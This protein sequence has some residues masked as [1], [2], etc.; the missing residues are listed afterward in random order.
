MGTGSSARALTRT[1]NEWF[2]EQTSDPKFDNRFGFFGVLPDW[3]DVDGTLAE[4]DY[5]YQTQRLC[6]GITTYTSYGGKLLGDSTFKPIWEKLQSYKALV[7]IHPT[8]L[9]ITPSHLAGSF[10]QPIIDFPLATTRTAADLV[11]S[12][13]M[14]S[15]PDVDVILSHAGGALPC[16][17]DRLSSAMQV[18]EIQ[19]Q[20]SV[21]V[22]QV[23]IGL[24]RFY[25]D[26]ALG[27]SAAQLYGLLETSDGAHVL[28][29]TDI[30]FAP[31]RI[32]LDK[33]QQYQKFVSSNE[34]GSE[35]APEVLKNN[36]L[37]LLNKH[38]QLQQPNM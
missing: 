27:T 37:A 2:G 23:E 10:P 6:Y 33:K 7:F 38:A 16:L 30:P 1:L 5:L 4:L 19:R 25:Y 21:T 8:A 18:P 34:R 35:I 13:T 3:Q 26:L 29:G 17:R 32:V 31:N 22:E 12:R 9:E 20:L 15:C 36:A 24:S 11:L 28:Y 14:E